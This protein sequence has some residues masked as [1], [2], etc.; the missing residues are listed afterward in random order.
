MTE[1]T[2]L[3]PE[4]QA[5]IGEKMDL[6]LKVNSLNV[7][8]SSPGF[9]DPLVTDIHEQTRIRRQLVCT[10]GLREVIAERIAAITTN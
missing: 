7:L 4:Q 9:I 10:E 8:I 6:D 5:L 1:Q 2:I 3:T